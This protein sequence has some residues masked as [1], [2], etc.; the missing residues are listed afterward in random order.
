MK[1]FTLLEVIGKSWGD[2]RSVS[3]SHEDVFMKR[4]LLLAFS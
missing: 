2:I 3:N 1:H 4:K